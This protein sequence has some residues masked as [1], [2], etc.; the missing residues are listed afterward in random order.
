MGWN[1]LEMAQVW[2]IPVT[3]ELAD[4]GVGDLTGAGAPQVWV[5]AVGAGDKTVL[6]GYTLP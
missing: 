6:L 5:A 3:G 1:G 2:R 4:F